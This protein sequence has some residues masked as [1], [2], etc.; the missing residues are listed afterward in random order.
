MAYTRV[1]SNLTLD[2]AHADGHVTTFGIGRNW[3]AAEPRVPGGSRFTPDLAGQYGW[4]YGEEGDLEYIEPLK[5]IAPAGLAPL[6]DMSLA[7]WTVTDADGNPVAADHP[8]CRWKESPIAGRFE[9]HK[10][11]HYYDGSIGLLGDRKF[12]WITSN[13]DLGL[14]LLVR[15]W[16][17]PPAERETDPVA[18]AIRSLGDGEGP[19]YAIK[20]PRRAMSEAA[21]AG[22]LPAAKRRYRRPTLLGKPQEED[23]FSFVDDFT[24]TGAGMNDPESLAHYQCI[25]IEY[26]DGWLIMNFLN[27]EQTWAYRGKWVS[28]GGKEIDQF[29]LTPGP[30]QILVSGQTGYFNIAEITY[31][32]KPILRPTRFFCVPPGVAYVPWY[33]RIASPQEYPHKGFPGQSTSPIFPN[34]APP[35]GGVDVVVDSEPL[36]YAPGEFATGCWRPKITFTS[37]NPHER[38]L[39]YNVQ[40]FRH[41]TIG[42]ATSNPVQSH[43]NDELKLLDMSGSL[44][45]RWRGAT[46]SATLQAKPGHTLPEIR[47]NQKARG[48]VSCDDGA[49]YYTQFTGYVVPP[50]KERP[51]KVKPVLL[52]V[53]AADWIEARG[54]NKDMYWHCSYEGWPLDEA[55][56]YIVHRGGVPDSMIDIQGSICE[57]WMG[58]DYYLPI[59]ETKGQRL[60]DFEPTVGLVE[61]LDTLTESCGVRWE[62]DD[63]HTGVRWGVDQHGMLFLHPT[64][65]HTPGHYDFT[66]D[67]DTVTEKDI[68]FSFSGLRSLDDFVNV[69]VV[70]A[71]KGTDATAAVMCDW[72]SIRDSS[73]PRFIGD[74]W[75]AIE[76]YS[77][78]VHVRAIA[79]RIWQRRLELSQV[80]YA[81]LHDHPELLPEDEL[82]VKMPD[83]DV[84]DGSIFRLSRKGWT[85]KARY[86]QRVEGVIVEAA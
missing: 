18:F 42:N 74:D 36:E 86:V 57:E 9:G 40:E 33:R 66:L 56:R 80:L 21:H 12:Q 79:E 65:W 55:F 46:L 84:T 64:Y 52:Q 54:R 26:S 44:N 29:K 77:D 41:P 78:A 28:E 83:V 61:A 45:D 27:R 6:A 58:S 32:T 85:A 8:D 60:L 50:E 35:W 47:P 10:W 82:R 2:N 31:P 72:A 73:D 19:E 51:G 67:D 17:M 22:L 5:A 25:W 38:G 49:S 53:E 59:S 11:L 39:L 15:A 4:D 20:L 3:A 16:L 62:D 14:N 48:D 24:S 70:M 7:D 43:A 75:G 1:A 30:I 13:D 81:E 23:S 76:T 69:I 63:H 68:V 34:A 37:D 71:E